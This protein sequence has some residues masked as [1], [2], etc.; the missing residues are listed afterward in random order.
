MKRN[1]FDF[2][3][4]L[5]DPEIYEENRLPAHSDHI[6]YAGARELASGKSSLRMSLDGVWQF[7]WSVNPASAPRGFERPDFDC[8]GWDRIRVP[9]HMQ[10]EGWGKPQYTNQ[11]YPWDG[12]EEILPGEIPQRYNPTGSYVRAFTVPRAWK[13]QRVC[14]SFQGVESGFALWLNGRY[15]GY[16]E[17][18]F[19][20]AEFELTPYLT[21]GE[22]KLA[23]QVY[24]W[25][26]GSW[27][28]DQD[29]FRFSGIFRSVYLY[30]VP[31]V[32][33]WDLSAVPLLADDFASAWLTIR[34]GILGSGSMDYAL[35]DADGEAI[36]EGHLAFEGD[37][38]FRAEPVYSEICLTRPKLWSAEEPY[39]YTL[40][41][42]MRDET[43]T[44]R[45]VIRQNVGFRRVEMDGGLMKLNGKRIV[46]KGVNRHD[47]S[48]V[49]GRA[50]RREE[51]EQDII[52]MK[53]HNI[54]AIRTS[55]YPDDS[56]LYELCDVY[57]LYL[58]AENNMETHGTWDP[59]LRR[60]RREE[61]W[62]FILP[63]D[64]AEWREMLLDRVNSCY[65]RDKNHPSILIWSC[66]NESFGGSV[67]HEMAQRFRELD[68]HRLVHYEGIFHDRRYPDTSDMESQM[69]T[70]AAG[71]REFLVEHPG[72]PFLSCEYMHSMGNSTGAMHK[73]TELTETEPR[74]QG[75]FIWDYIDQSIGKRDRYGKE[76]PACGG[77]FDD[78]PNNGSF[79][80]DGL[81]YGGGRL[82]SP[83]MQEVKFQYQNIAVAFSGDTYIVRNRNLFLG[84]DTFEASVTLTA[85]GR[86]LRT[87]PV[88][89]AV[90]ALSEETYVLPEEITAAMQEAAENAAAAGRPE[91]E[92]TVTVSFALRRDTRWAKA[93]YEIAFGQH[94]FP[95]KAAAYRTGGG[96]REKLRVIH[97]KYNIGVK[98]EDFSAMFSIETPGMTSYVYGGVEM[99]RAIPVPN[100]WRAPVENDRGNFMPQRYA[101]WKTASLYLTGDPLYKAAG[102]HPVLGESGETARENPGIEESEG[103]VRVTYRYV[104]PTVPASDCLV[105]YTVSGDGTVEVKLHYDVVRSLGDMPEF[106]MLFKLDADYD[107]LTW[108]G[109]GP[110]ETYADRCRGAKLG[111]YENRVAD[112][113]ARYLVPQ[114]CGN[115][116][117]V[118]WAKVTDRR[119]RGLLFLA[120]SGASP[121][122]SGISSAGSGTS[123]VDFGTDV[124]PPAGS[125]TGGM[126]FS[127]LPWTPH[128]I[129]NAA[130]AYELP[131]VHYTVV[132]AAMQQMGVGGDDSWGARVHPEYLID[133]SGEAIE[134]SFR[135]RGI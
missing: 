72:K 49:S 110:E 48:S 43:R 68:P 77:D 39:L 94:V 18:S 97:G 23:V 82:P 2:E 32:H 117:G 119:G 78:R 46:F 128:E 111:I 124:M 127:T 17:D 66:G 63:N 122:G 98:G 134:F 125:G 74:Y 16:S 70:S 40:Y 6:C 35:R 67:I 15:V 54:N 36:A 3:R 21:D 106:G 92:F 12:H 120:G 85:D 65:Q 91:P 34:A 113:M 116:C 47:F 114:E 64:H 95:G 20:P 13:G 60:G 88:Q 109:L 24:T 73:Y 103:T 84:T 102:E 118:R 1:G 26:A 22:N 55:H 4:V 38:C 133:T 53:R 93:G 135:F 61:D 56:V 131:P 105:T 100:F 69:Y 7:A 81:V 89:T 107:R 50:V 58:I 27:C 129:E 96:G 25:T 42:E 28:E 10:M 71:I 104:M 57:G 80:G 112:N 45:E 44:T 75:G 8:S 121:A 101:Q 5:R 52:T 115:H 123:L 14:I 31:A 83:K 9:A 29:F 99:L 19:D 87:V 108:Y 130:H 59:Y 62:D 11:A 37:D 30:A 33:L 79:S 126:S 132:R 86:S 90:E 51:T 41:L 76:F